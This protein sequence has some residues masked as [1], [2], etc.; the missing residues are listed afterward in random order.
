MINWPTCFTFRLSS[1]CH[2]DLVLTLE[3]KSSDIIS[4]VKAETQDKESEL[5][6]LFIQLIDWCA[7]RLFSLL[8]PNI[9]CENGPVG[10]E[11]I[12]QQSPTKLYDWRI[13]FVPLLPS[14]STPP[15]P[16]TAN[17]VAASAAQV[18]VW[19]LQDP[20][21]WCQ[22]PL[23][24]VVWHWMWLQHDGLGSS[25]PLSWRPFQPFQLWF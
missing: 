2:C 4:N 19:G 25:W 11:C 9:H 18:W 23:C 17:L 15:T 24:Q 5:L 10:L 1:R 14:V 20:C 12:W 16:P 13:L 3:A 8:S 6:V 21:R 7:F 22:C